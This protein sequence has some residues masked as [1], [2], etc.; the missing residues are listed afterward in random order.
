[1]N[2]DTERKPQHPNVRRWDTNNPIFHIIR[3]RYRSFTCSRCGKVY[4]GTKST[5]TYHE[6][7]CGLIPL[8]FFFS[9]R[10]SRASNPRLRE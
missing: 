3:N 7:A 10:C 1:M 8:N 6:S 9:D 2:D 4:L 5:Q